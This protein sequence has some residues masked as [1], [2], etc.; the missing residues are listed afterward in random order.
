MDKTERRALLLE[1]AKCALS[2]T[3]AHHWRI[4]EIAGQ[5]IQRCRHCGE[6]RP[7]QP[8]HRA[9]RDFHYGGEQAPVAVLCWPLRKGDEANGAVSSEGQ[10]G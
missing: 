9:A 1:V 6:H 10:E 8:P 2:P 4:K 7:I 3:G 5:M